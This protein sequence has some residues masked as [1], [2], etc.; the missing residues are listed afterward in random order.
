MEVKTRYDIDKL[1]IRYKGV[2]S[3]E[4]LLSFFRSWLKDNNFFILEPK[5][6]YRPKE[7]EVKLTGILKRNEYVMYTVEVTLKTEDVQD[8]ELV[9]EGKKLNMQEGKLSIIF[10][11]RMELDWQKRFQ[12]N[13]LLIA[14]QDFFHKYIIKKKI[15][16]EWMDWFDKRFRQFRNEVEAKVFKEE[17]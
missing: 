13:K 7:Q 9:K 5:Y 2:F 15:E 8:I 12:G 14:L 6:K 17:E 16:E 3:F 11:G 10:E 4:E 1:R